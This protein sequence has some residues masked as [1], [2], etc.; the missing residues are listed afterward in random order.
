MGLELVEPLQDHPLQHK[1]SP[2]EEE[3]KDKGGGDPIKLL[4]EGALERQH[5]EMMDIFSQILRRIAIGDALPSNNQ[6]GGTT[7]FKVQVN[8]Y[9]PRFE[10]YIGAD[11]L[12]KWLNILEGYFSLHKFSHREN[13]TFSLV[14]VAPPCQKLVGNLL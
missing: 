5:N 2:M 7:P 11:A 10:G 14:K 1:W 13:I 6:F 4:L 3:K 8:F 12:D 9:I